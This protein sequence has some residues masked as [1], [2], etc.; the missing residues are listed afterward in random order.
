MY[1]VLSITFFIVAAAAL[2]HQPPA[3][4]TA[5]LSLIAAF[6]FASTSDR[7]S[8]PLLDILGGLAL[9]SGVVLILAGI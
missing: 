5:G 6:Y 7:R 4:S 8:Q 9:I 2:T 1:A 3:F